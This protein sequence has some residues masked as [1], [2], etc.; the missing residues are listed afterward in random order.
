MILL[1]DNHDSF[2]Y[3]LGRYVGELGYERE[4]VRSDHLGLDGIAARAPS[5]IILSPGPG[6]R[7]TQ[8]SR[9][10]SSSASPTAFRSSACA[11]VISVSARS[12]EGVSCGHGVRSTARPPR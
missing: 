5:H 1:I 11:W 6:T 12:S 3:N 4:V 10:R 8:G 7:T 9:T 2:V